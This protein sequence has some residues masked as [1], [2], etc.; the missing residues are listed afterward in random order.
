MPEG[1][2]ERREQLPV[3]ADQLRIGDQERHQVAEMLRQAAGEGRIDLEELDER[4]DAT[5]AAKTY[6]DLVPLTAD[7]PDT[8][9]GVAA[10]RPVAPSRVVAGPSRENAVAILSGVE[11]KGVWVV[12][13]RLNIVCF[14]GGADLDLRDAQFAAKEV[15]INVIAIMGGADITVGPDVHVVV[16]GV[17]VMGAFSGPGGRRDVEPQVGPGSPVVRV[18]GLALMGGVDVNRKPPRASN[19]Q[20][21]PRG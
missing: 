9:T 8:T 12:P 13:E 16:E 5:Y 10:T 18:K 11:R 15:T 7:L 6:G 21:P 4:L 14:M 3:Q 17:G 2:G 20:L 1:Q 19:G